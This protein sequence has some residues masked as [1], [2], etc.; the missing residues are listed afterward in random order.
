MD[1]QELLGKAQDAITVGRVFGEPYEKNGVT[2]IPAASVGGGGGGGGGEGTEEGKG[3]G[4]GSGVGFG[5]GGHPAG[6]FVIKDGNVTWHP[7]L[8]LNRLIARAQIVA[9]VALLTIRVLAKKRKR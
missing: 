1:V 3:T 2:I 5:I 4:S 7:A 8:D 9:I 6:A